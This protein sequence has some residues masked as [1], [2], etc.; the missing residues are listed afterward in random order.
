[1]E[2]LF[3]CVTAFAEYSFMEWLW[4]RVN[5]SQPRLQ[6]SKSEAPSEL[7]STEKTSIASAK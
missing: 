4:R 1:M 3:D 2:F 5:A 6:P 7:R